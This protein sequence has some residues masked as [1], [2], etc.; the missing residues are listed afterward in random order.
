MVM[1]GIGICC[2]WCQWQEGALILGRCFS[3][4]SPFCLEQ[5]SLR[6]C[7]EGHPREGGHPFQWPWPMTGRAV[8]SQAL[9]A[10][11]CYSGLLCRTAG[12]FT[13][14]KRA[15]PSSSQVGLASLS[16][17]GPGQP[18][19]QRSP[20]NSARRLITNFLGRLHSPRW[21]PP[22]LAH[23]GTAL[24]LPGTGF[25]P[26]DR[27]SAP[28]RAPRRAAT[29]DALP[30]PLAEPSLSSIIIFFFW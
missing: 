19:A 9:A 17:A 16:V 11:A 21:A 25:P 24:S 8:A 7:G 30:V 2:W 1:E 27:G 18:L 29:G 15:L 26:R 14:E 5:S 28:G 13:V 20:A 12:R 4:H 10:C 23:P 22:S 3:S 6:L